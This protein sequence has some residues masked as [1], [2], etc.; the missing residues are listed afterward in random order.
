MGFKFNSDLSQPYYG[1]SGGTT[2]LV[3]FDAD[4]A[5]G[6]HPYRI[7]WSADQPLQYTGIDTLREQ[8]DQSEDVGEQSVSREAYWRRAV[9]SWHVGAGQRY[10]D[11]PDSDRH[12][13][14][15]SKGINVW[16]RF[17]FSLLHDTTFE[18]LSNATNL[19]L[20]VVGTHLY[21][22][23]GT[24]IKYWTN[25]TGGS[26][27]DITGEPGVQPTSIVSD[28]FNVFTSHG[29]SGIYKTTRGAATTASHIT[30]TCDLLGY[31]RG[32]FLAATGKHLRDV[33]AILYGAG[34]VA[35]TTGTSLLD[36]S[37]TDWTWTGIA[38]G[39]SH[40]YAAGF[41]GDKSLIYHIHIKSDGT[42]LDAPIVAVEL[43]DGEVVR[44]IKGYLGR[45]LFIGTD[46]GYRF[47]IVQDSGDL[48]VGA[49]VTTPAPVYDFEPQGEFVW[50]SLANFE[51][52]SGLGRFSTSQFSDLDNLVPA[53]ASDLLVSGQSANVL[54][55]V[56][57]QNVR[58]FTI[59]A[60][61]FFYET[62]DLVSSGFIDS[63]II[64][65]NLTEPKVG[66]FLEAEHGGTAGEHSVS[67][68]TDGGAFIA[69]GEHDEGIVFNLG[70][71][72]ADTFE[73]RHTLTRDGSNHTLGLTVKSWLMRVQPQ[74]ALTDFI[75]VT[76]FLTD[77]VESLQDAYIYYSTYEEL[78]YIAGLYRTKE[79]TTAQWGERSDTVVVERYQ[80]SMREIA[81]GQAGNRGFN[82][83]CLLELKR[84]F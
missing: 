81:E 53:Y 61:G 25:V 22:T 9:N 84:I 12:R 4:F 2:T 56:T 43:P 55:I 78:E 57:F 45:F 60:I 31:A 42:G 5:L 70:Q 76:I 37:N 29:S 71:V 38:E 27:T 36:H 21:A 82:A 14:W 64:N 44:T 77:Q 79:I 3:P 73:I 26:A 10:Y 74:P 50:Y 24:D 16:E 30:G 66:L 1:G 6:G 62:T 8:S 23:V 18:I 49:L 59:D 32:R 54:S 52:A 17:Q 15:N 51:G 75:Q 28:G 11:R 72:Q 46:K 63:G 80:M 19:R 65:F 83:S 47:A 39:S 48:T 34:G 33:T 67:I 41:S 20:I 58:M 35:I 7:D 13:F 68:S 69:L 40:I